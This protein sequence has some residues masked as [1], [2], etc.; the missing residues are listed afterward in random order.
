MA[1]ESLALCATRCEIK[2]DSARESAP[3]GSMARTEGQV[4]GR[5]CGS[6][7]IKAEITKLTCVRVWG[8][9]V[10][11]RKEGEGQGEESERK[12]EEE[13]EEEEEEGTEEGGGGGGLLWRTMLPAPAYAS[14]TQCPVPRGGRPTTELFRC[15]PSRTTGYM[16][17]PAIAY[18]T[19]RQIAH[20]AE[21]SL[22]SVTVVSYS[23]ALFLYL[24]CPWYQSARSVPDIA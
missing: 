8:L 10:G 23:Y 9:G 2:S 21:Y 11:V 18:Q 12:A 3:G 4:R 19:R 5:R 15:F 1:A 17:V 22:L 16:S 14:D 20:S 13:E 6:E 24:P 7:P